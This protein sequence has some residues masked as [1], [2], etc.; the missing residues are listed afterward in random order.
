MKSI[1]VH[2]AENDYQ[3]LKAIA[4]RSGRPVAELIRNAMAEYLKQERGNRHSIRGIAAHPS[5]ALKKPWDRSDLLDEM[6]RR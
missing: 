2:V 5:G 4:A 6:T 1:S 3:E